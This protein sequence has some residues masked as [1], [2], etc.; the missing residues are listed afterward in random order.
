[1]VSPEE[2]KLLGCIILV[3]WSASLL[4][5]L[6]RQ[7]DDDDDGDDDEDEKAV[8]DQVEEPHPLALPDSCLGPAQWH[9]PHWARQQVRW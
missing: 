3:N 6:V 9:H 4:S 5:H 2:E 8:A 1:M 7:V